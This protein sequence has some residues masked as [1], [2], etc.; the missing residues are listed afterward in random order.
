MNVPLTYVF[1]LA[2]ISGSMSCARRFIS[3][4][5]R[6]LFL[7]PSDGWVRYKRREEKRREEKRMKQLPNY[8]TTY[9]QKVFPP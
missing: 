8:N 2:K 3:N 4:T 1:L 9:G 7:L 6:D 5:F